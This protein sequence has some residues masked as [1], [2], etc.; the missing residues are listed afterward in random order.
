MDCII[1]NPIIYRE[2]P[3]KEVELDLGSRNTRGLEKIQAKTTN[4]I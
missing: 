2:L 4:K 1:K 3:G